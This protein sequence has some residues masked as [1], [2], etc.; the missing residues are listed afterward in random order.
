MIGSNIPREEVDDEGNEHC[1][2]THDAHVGF[3]VVVEANRRGDGKEYGKRQRKPN[4]ADDV[5]FE[6]V[7]H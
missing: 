6:V 7:I 3:D 5:R 1:G 4:F 2:R